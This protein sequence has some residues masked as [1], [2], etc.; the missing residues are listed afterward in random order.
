MENK[1][2][3]KPIAFDVDMPVKGVRRFMIYA[4]SEEEAI[5]KADNYA[6]ELYD[7]EYFEELEWEKPYV[8]DADE[9]NTHP[10]YCTNIEN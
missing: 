2:Y 10:K 7:T 4:R 9:G 5:K 8:I 3:D 1:I 6:L